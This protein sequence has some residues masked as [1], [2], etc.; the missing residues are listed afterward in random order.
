MLRPVSRIAGLVALAAFFVLL[1]GLPVL[2]GF[3]TLQG[4]RRSKRSIDRARWF[5]AAAMSCCRS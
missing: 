3:A 5:S 1:G 2:R 4:L